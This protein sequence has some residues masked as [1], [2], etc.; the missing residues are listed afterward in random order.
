MPFPYC[1]GLLFLDNVGTGF[2]LAV[3]LGDQS[4]HFLSFSNVMEV[5]D[6]PDGKQ[7]IVDGMLSTEKK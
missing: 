5:L 2:A 4:V 1:S 6:S 7:G 3:R